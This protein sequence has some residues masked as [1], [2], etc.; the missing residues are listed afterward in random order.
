MLLGVPLPQRCV[1]L[2]GGLEQRRT[3]LVVE[4]RWIKEIDINP[5]LASPERIIALDARLSDEALVALARELPVVVTGRSLE[6]PH[7]ASLR[8]DNF[9]GAREATNY[10]LD[11]GHLRIAFITGDPEHQDA[12]ERQ[13]GYLSALAERGI[14]V[15]P[16]L[17]IAGDYRERSG[18]QAVL[19]LLKQGVKFTAVFAAND[20]M[21]L[22]ALLGL[23]QQHVS[24][25]QQVSVIGFDDLQ[26][27]QFSIPPLT[28]VHQ[29][30]LETGQLAARAMSALLE[31]RR[32]KLRMPQP[33]LVVRESTGPCPAA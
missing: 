28:S 7:L 22:G 11:L 2:L 16:K 27:G 24:V 5:L 23:Y 21:A 15:D 3:L 17:I 8:F 14:P 31:G 32:S 13:R 9:G 29:P 1:V 20:Q 6:A 33:R 19:R 30:S 4:Q 10:L 12:L 18:T 25:P 26:V